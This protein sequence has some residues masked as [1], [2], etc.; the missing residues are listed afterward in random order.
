M[1]K[2]TKTTSAKVASTASKILKDGRYGSSSKTK[3]R[4]IV[5]F[6]NQ[7]ESENYVDTNVKI[8]VYESKAIWEKR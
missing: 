4:N 5:L 1:A 2:N 7:R 3:E 8:E 6:C